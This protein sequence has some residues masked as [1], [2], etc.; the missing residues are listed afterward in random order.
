MGAFTIEKT[1]NLYWLGRYIERVYQTINAYEKVFDQMI[2]GNPEIYHD[3]CRQLDIQDFYLNDAHFMT[4]YLY[5]HN[6]PDSIASNLQ[7]AYNNAIVLREDISSST[8]SYIQMACNIFEEMEYSDAPV[9]LL[10]QVKDNILAFWGS[11]DETVDEAEKNVVKCG[12]YVERIDMYLRLD[13]KKK[14]LDKGIS[15][16]NNR[17]IHLEEVFKNKDINEYMIDETAEHFMIKERLNDLNT[18]FM[19]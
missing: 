14:D 7:R 19:V 4:S 1:N 2:D 18:L 11:V 13:Y 12:K 5:D 15:K 10:Q 3:F 17:V 9:L 6:N 16:L 8:L